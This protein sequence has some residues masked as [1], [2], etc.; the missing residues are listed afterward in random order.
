MNPISKPW[1]EPAPSIPLPEVSVKGIY[2]NKNVWKPAMKQ[3]PKKLKR[4]VKYEPFA[5][6]ADESTV[7]EAEQVISIDAHLIESS[8]DLGSPSQ[9]IKDYDSTGELVYSRN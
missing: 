6:G 4:K 5:N 8:N 3:G 7:Q 2:R 1:R 9:V